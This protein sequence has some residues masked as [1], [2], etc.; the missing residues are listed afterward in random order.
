MQYTRAKQNLPLPTSATDDMLLTAG[1]N[2]Q[3]AAANGRVG[4]RSLRHP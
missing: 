4:S 2:A 1:A 3:P